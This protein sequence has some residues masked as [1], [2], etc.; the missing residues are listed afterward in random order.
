M[1]KMRIFSIFLTIVLLLSTVCV[2]ASAN[3]DNP[4]VYNGCHSV[5]A[6]MTLSEEQQLTETAKS[7]ILYELNSDTMLYTWNPDEKIYPTSMVKMMTALV[8]IEN[9]NLDDVVTI[10][11]KM[12][13][14]VPI[15]ILGMDLKSGEEITLRD[16]LYAN[17]VESATDASVVIAHHVAGSTAEFLE[18]MNAKAYEMGCKNTH[19]SNV[20]G[21][22][23][24]ET[25][26]TARDICRITEIALENEIFRDMFQ[27]SNYTIPAT[28]KQPERDLITTNH[29]MNER[30]KKYYYELVTGGKTG[31]TDQGGRCLTITSEKDGMNILCIVMGA[32]PTVEENG[33]LSAYG[34]FEESRILIDYAFSNFEFRQVFYDGQSLSQHSVVNGANDVVTQAT[35]TISTILPVGVDEEQLRWI[36]EATGDTITA[37]VKKGQKLGSVQVWFGSKCLAETD[38]V[39]MNKVEVYQAPVVPEKPQK[40]DEGNWLVVILILVG[41]VFA[42]FLALVSIRFVRIMIYQRKQ[43]NR[44][45]RRR[46]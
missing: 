16:L 23:D 8:A 11:R 7:V 15:G 26:T 2:P 40:A 17:M 39:A 33:N 35:S 27:A 43:E 30:N 22:H 9:G 45:R 34:S 29:M 12:L 14:E 38:M 10:T 42:V 25:Y 44:G 20:H 41:T 36:Y 32:V 21:L 31:A 1:K 24:E 3:N 46:R 18:L 37:P 19:Y 28:N 13:N 4:A 6:G 5:D